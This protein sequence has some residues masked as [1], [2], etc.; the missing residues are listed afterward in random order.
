MI[1]R[2]LALGYAT[3]TI[4]GSICEYP[5]SKLT[6]SLKLVEEFMKYVKGPFGQE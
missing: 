6:E 2:V 4:F 3:W 1:G 5:C